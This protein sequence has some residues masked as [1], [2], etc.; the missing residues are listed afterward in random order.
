MN[1]ESLSDLRGRIRLTSQLEFGTDVVGDNLDDLRMSAVEGV[2]AE[3]VV[4]ASPLPRW[5]LLH[6]EVFESPVDSGELTACNGR[7]V[8]K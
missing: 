1:N 8:E 3:D 7:G 6:D 4:L 2:V 5:K